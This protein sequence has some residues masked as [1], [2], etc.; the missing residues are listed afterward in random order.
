MGKRICLLVFVIIAGIC[1]TGA[2]ASNWQ[3]VGKMV[4]GSNCYLDYDSVCLVQYEINYNYHINATIKIMPTTD[5]VFK[6]YGKSVASIIEQWKLH[7]REGFYE[8]VSRKI[9]G[10]DG[11]MIRKYNA[12]QCEQDGGDMLDGTISETIFQKCWHILGQGR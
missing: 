8:V 2:F 12:K 7:G 4:D 10:T 6:Q 5:V 3:L 11:K 9:Y 1:T